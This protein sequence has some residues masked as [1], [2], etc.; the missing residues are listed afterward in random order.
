[1]QIQNAKVIVRLIDFNDHESYKLGIEGSDVVFCAVGTTQQKVKGNKEAYR[2]VDYDITVNSARFCKETGCENYVL[3]SSVG[4]NSNSGNFYLKIKGEVEDAVKSFGIEQT[5]IFRP[6]I[7][8][9][10]RKENRPAER[11]G[12]VLM[13]TFS[14]ALM[15]KLSKYKPVY[16]NDVAKAMITASKKNIPGF[17]IYEYG[18]MMQLIG[19]T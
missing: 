18:E 5:S 1:M 13:N 4:A 3:V 16:A 14:F 6:S 2:K 11:V 7:L 15:G 12:Q 8:L 17:N 10:E 9:G 19:K